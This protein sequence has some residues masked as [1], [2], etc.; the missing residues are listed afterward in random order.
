MNVAPGPRI[1]LPTGHADGTIVEQQ[2]GD[3]A[4][5]VNDVEEALH[6]HVQEGRIANH[7]NDLLVFF[8]IGAALV[9]TERHTHRG[10]H[11]NAGIKRIPRLPEAER[12]TTD[13]ARN[14]DVSQ[15]RQ[16]VIDAKVRAGHTHRRR[17]WKNLHRRYSGR[18]CHPI[19]QRLA[20]QAGDGRLQHMRRQFA[21]TWQ[22]VL[23]ADRDSLRHGTPFFNYWLGKIGA[24]PG[25]DPV[26][27]IIGR[28]LTIAYFGF[29]VFLWVYTAFGFEKTKPVPERVTGHD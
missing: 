10:T 11:R 15:L 8:G 22:D 19:R 13:I 1:A 24:G 5:V 27:T 4:T 17:P 21:A 6:A 18:S 25:T 2:Y 12:V 9:E 20:K 3:I 28:I 7:G 29:F 14:G 16:G 23:A 26:E